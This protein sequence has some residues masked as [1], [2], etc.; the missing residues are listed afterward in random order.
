[1][2][3]CLLIASLAGIAFSASAFAR[4]ETDTKVTVTS[5]RQLRADQVNAPGNGGF[6][7]RATR[8]VYDATDVGVPDGEFF[9]NGTRPADTAD[10]IS[11]T[12]NGLGATAYPLTLTTL[13]F[14]FETA[15]I[16]TAFDVEVTIFDNIDGTNTAGV[17]AFDTPLAQFVVGFVDVIDAGGY[18]TGDIDLSPAAV[19]ITDGGI[20]IRMR[21]LVAD[22]ADTLAAG[23]VTMLFNDCYSEVSEQNLQKVGSSNLFYYRDVDLNGSIEANEQRYFGLNDATKFLMSIGAETTCLGSSDFNSD[24]FTDFFDFDDFVA[25]FDGGC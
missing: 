22:T 18:N 21:F 5:L 14:A 9:Y 4:P 1:M 13:N 11:L 10:D 8:L 7:A 16:D 12:L 23:S 17:P 6:G 24:G 20:A 15:G 25:A 2:K 19:S 3:N